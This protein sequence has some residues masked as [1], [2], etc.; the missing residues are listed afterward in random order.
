MKYN[1]SYKKVCL[2]CGKEFEVKARNSKYCSKECS[3]KHLN[4]VANQKY[5]EERAKILE[6]RKKRI[7]NVSGIFLAGD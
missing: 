3:N 2:M 4:E 7:R 1:K 6:Y 5:H